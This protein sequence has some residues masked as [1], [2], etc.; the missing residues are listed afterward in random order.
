MEQEEDTVAELN[1]TITTGCAERDQRASVLTVFAF[2]I[3]TLLT[4][5]TNHSS[6]SLNAS[7]QCRAILAEEST[8]STRL[9]EAVCER[10][11]RGSC[12]Q[13]AP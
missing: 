4:G 7:Q 11:G 10:E 6:Q 2:L 13:D 5:S 3:F 1:G 9:W 12:L 8:H